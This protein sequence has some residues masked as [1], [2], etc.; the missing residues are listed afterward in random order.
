MK[1]QE[2]FDA[3][4]KRLSGVPHE[5]LEERFGFLSEMI[6]DRI[7]EGIPEE[8]AVDALGSVDKVASQI[9]A[10]IPLATLV[11]EKVRPKRK[12]KAWEMV[13]L[14]LGSPIWLSLLVAAAVVILALYIVLWALVISLWAVF[15]SLVAC[16]LALV[17]VGI[18]LACCGR[19][20]TGLALMGVGLVCAGLSIFLFFGCVW[21]SKGIV[22]LAKNI[23]IWIKNC[24]VKK[25]EQNE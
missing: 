11:K 15:V 3:L 20:L 12:I 23:G 2:F 4:K 22:I 16:A 1:K 25:E 17:T 19:G 6:D 5:E 14:A 10:D 21:A 7:E 13:L 8:E 18:V 9:V 24:F